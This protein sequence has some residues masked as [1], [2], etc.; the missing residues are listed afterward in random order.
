[1]TVISLYSGAGGIEEGLSQCGIK[2]DIAIDNCEKF[3]GQDPLHTIKLNHPDTEVICGNVGDFIESL[4]KADIVVG[5]PPCPEFSRAKR[6]RT[7]NMCEVNNFW[8]AVEHCKPKYFLMENVQDIK[9]GLHAMSHLVDCADYGVPQNRVRRFY[10]NISLPSAT[11]AE[12]P[13]QNIFGLTQKKWVSIKDALGLDGVLLD[14][15]IPCYKSKPNTTS[16]DRPSRTIL[17]DTAGNVVFFIEDRKTTFGNKNRRYSIEKPSATIL[18]DCR[19]WFF[20]PKN[21]RGNQIE[22]SRSIDLPSYTIT[23]RS[24]FS[25]TNQKVFSTKALKQSPSLETE[26]P[27]IERKLTNQ[28]LAVLQGFPRE[29]KFF[30]GKGS[31]RRQIGNA[32][33]P[34]VIKAF[35]S[36]VVI[37]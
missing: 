23:T 3:P 24:E 11:H 21:R 6:G 5:G 37:S 30:G 15:S 27:I 28:E 16:T 26:E 7:F 29:Y 34:P 32:V 25:L 4:P 31:V 19:F 9:K 18:T 35:F 13:Q 2:T 10:T 20:A 1:M 14:K 22:L 12:N 36:Q 17:T 8:K 33:P